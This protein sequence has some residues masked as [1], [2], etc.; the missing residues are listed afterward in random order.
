M[1]CAFCASVIASA[2]AGGRFCSPR[3]HLS[4]ITPWGNAAVADDQTMALRAVTLCEDHLSSLKFDR[5][6]GSHFFN[7][8]CYQVPQILPVGGRGPYAVGIATEHIRTP[9]ATV[10]EG[11]GDSLPSEGEHRPLELM[12]QVIFFRR[13]CFRLSVSLIPPAQNVPPGAE[14]STG[15]AHSSCCVPLANNYRH[16]W[17]FVRGGWPT[18]GDTFCFDRGTVAP[19]HRPRCSTRWINLA[20]RNCR[21]SRP[22]SSDSAGRWLL[23]QEKLDACRSA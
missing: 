23:P 22:A 2:L 8:R 15:R 20:W 9:V 18:D 12:A 1:R 14:R 17:G 19:W 16:V 6:L 13:D 3:R 5:P 11:D 10:S 21:G 7:S 4:T